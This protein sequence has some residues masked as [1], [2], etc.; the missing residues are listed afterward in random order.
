MTV[1][2]HFVG[3]RKTTLFKLYIIKENDFTFPQFQPCLNKSSFSQIKNPLVI[4]LLR[5][6][7]DLVLT[8]FM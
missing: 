5:L 1:S 6:L 4:K 2:N 3:Q 8:T 7:C